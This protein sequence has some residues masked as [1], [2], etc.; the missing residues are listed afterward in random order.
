[1]YVAIGGLEYDTGETQE[2]IELARV[3][4]T[5]REVPNRVRF[6][7]AERNQIH[8]DSGLSTTLA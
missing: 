4:Q 1:M 3:V 2:N 5:T 6:C 7:K 8:A